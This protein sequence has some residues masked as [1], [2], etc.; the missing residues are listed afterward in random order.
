MTAPLPYW[1]SIWASVGALL[2]TL[3]FRFLGPLL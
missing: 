3:H 1:S 2:L